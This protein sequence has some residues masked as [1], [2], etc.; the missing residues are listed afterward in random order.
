[1]K[2]IM[3]PVAHNAP[4][5]KIRNCIHLLADKSRY[6]LLLFHVVSIPTV[7]DS[8]EGIV[9]GAEKTIE[10][11]REKEEKAFREFAELIIADGYTV[12]ISVPIGFFDEKFIS[13]ANEVKPSFIIMFTGGSHGLLEDMFGTNASFVFE[14]VTPPIFIISYDYNL[15]KLSKAVVGLHL[16]NERL[17]VLGDYFHF[18]DEHKLESNFIKID[19]RLQLDIID[20][21]KVLNQLQ[22]MY[23]GKIEFIVHRSSE[24]IAEGL[25][26]YADE[27]GSDVI[28]LFT[29]K[30]NFIEK[31]FHRSVAR[32]LVLHSKKPLLIYHY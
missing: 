20:D 19:H 16:E 11:I 8:I 15:K 28:V 1:M 30:R 25:E 3:I 21:G 2:T 22:K 32:D 23:P 12:D 27:S 18:A 26:K 31:L 29:T 17:A 4:K 14:K 5:E 7:G 9:V 6:R 24:D 13:T 10:D